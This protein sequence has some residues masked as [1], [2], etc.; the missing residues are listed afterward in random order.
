M[1]N[2]DIVK[3][4]LLGVG[5]DWG[6]GGLGRGT[7]AAEQPWQQMMEGWPVVRKNNYSLFP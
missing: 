6:A 7:V 2:E 1:C 4:N 5:A 3:G